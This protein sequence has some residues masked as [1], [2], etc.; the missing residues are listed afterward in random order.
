[1]VQKLRSAS[2]DAK[3]ALSRP[4]RYHKV[5]RNLEVKEVSVG[6]VQ[7]IGCG[8]EDSLSDLVQSS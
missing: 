2:S 8:G 7:E 3:E 6:E 4:G 1:M 5:A